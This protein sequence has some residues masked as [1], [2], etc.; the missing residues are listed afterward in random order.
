MVGMV[1]TNWNDKW[2]KNI[3]VYLFYGILG[4]PLVVH[5][6]C[7]DSIGHMETQPKLLARA[8]STVTLGTS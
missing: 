2:G 1:E 5:V 4:K 3:L 7:I 6:G 8:I